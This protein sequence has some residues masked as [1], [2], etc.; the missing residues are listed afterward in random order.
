MDSLEQKR[1][2]YKLLLYKQCL[3]SYLSC[4]TLP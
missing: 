4:I 1:E 2:M 3:L